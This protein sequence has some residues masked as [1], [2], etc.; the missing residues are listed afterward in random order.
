MMMRRWRS[1]TTAAAV[2]AAERCFRTN[3]GV[4]SRGSTLN[5]TISSD[6]A[7]AA[8]RT[9]SK[10]PPLLNP[11]LFSTAIHGGGGGGIDETEGEE[12]NDEDDDDDDGWEEEE[13]VEAKYGDGGDGGGVVLG[14]VA[15][16]ARALSLA[17]E[18]LGNFDVDTVLYAFRVSLKGY[19]YV[20][21]DKL[22]NK[23]GC[24]DVE[25]M[26][27]FSKLY[28]GRLDEVGHF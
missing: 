28:K 20:R 23:Y 21:L 14:D 18:V 2:L 10:L 19:I 26:E 17:R 11:K 8:S 12:L 27:K 24:L 1:I 22:T 6:V 16:G 4:L 5:N 3:H 15:W 13:E 25:E 9:F 7:G